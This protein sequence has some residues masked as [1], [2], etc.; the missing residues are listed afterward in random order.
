[1]PSNTID[2]LGEVELRRY[3][4]QAGV[5]LSHEELPLDQRVILLRRAR[6]HVVF[7]LRAIDQRLA[8][9]D[10]VPEILDEPLTEKLDTLTIETET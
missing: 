7:V 2:D 5:L 3:L 9:A 8:A 1:M 10:G 4:R 6:H